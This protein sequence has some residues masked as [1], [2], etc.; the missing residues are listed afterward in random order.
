MGKHA[1]CI[2]VSVCLCE[3]GGTPYHG[4]YRKAPPERGTSFFRFQAY[5]RLRV[6][7]VQVYLRVAKYVILVGKNAQKG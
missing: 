5:E 7:R 2:L 1:S 6:S 3:R 4:L